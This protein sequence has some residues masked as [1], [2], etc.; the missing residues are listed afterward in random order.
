[1]TRDLVPRAAGWQPVLGNL[2]VT[3]GWYCQETAARGWPSGADDPVFLAD[4]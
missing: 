1:M 3:S 2:W 4:W